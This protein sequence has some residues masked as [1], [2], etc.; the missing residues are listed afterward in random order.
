MLAT[1]ST[2]A[3]VP[4]AMLF[5]ALILYSPTGGRAAP[6]GETAADYYV[7]ASPYQANDPALCTA[8]T[9]DQWGPVLAG[10][11]WSRF[12]IAWVTAPAAPGDADLTIDYRI[13]DL[14]NQ[15]FWTAVRRVHDPFYHS[16]ADPSH[17]RRIFNV[18][19]SAAMHAGGQ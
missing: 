1:H 14:G 13:V 19:P 2:W 16:L 7:P 9:A 8:L 5:S 4:C 18:H 6:P 3:R 11:A 17:Y 10:D 15:P 12:V